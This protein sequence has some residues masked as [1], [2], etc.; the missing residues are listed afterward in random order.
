MR[1]TTGHAGFQSLICCD[2]LIWSLSWWFSRFLN[3]NGQH[4][5]DFLI[6]FLKLYLEVL[7]PGSRRGTEEEIFFFI[8]KGKILVLWKLERKA[9]WQWRKVN[10]VVKTGCS[11]IEM[12]FLNRVV[13]YWEWGFKSTCLTLW[14][15]PWGGGI[16]GNNYA[17]ANTI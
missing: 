7:F 3:S 8:F 10:H 5:I 12:I 2:M 4:K 17:Y 14:Q 13:T 16:S 1:P 11:K 6:N 9:S 15:G